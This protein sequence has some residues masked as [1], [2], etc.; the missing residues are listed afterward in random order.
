MF[1]CLRY[2]QLNFTENY[3][4]LTVRIILYLKAPLNEWINTVVAVVHKNILIMFVQILLKNQTFPSKY[5]GSV[6]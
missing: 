2:F 1:K 6:I 4:I 5:N 3:M